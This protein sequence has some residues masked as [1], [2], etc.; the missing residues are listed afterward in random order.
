MCPPGPLLVFAVLGSPPTA[1][2]SSLTL[3]GERWDNGQWSAL[4]KA[5]HMVGP[6][7]KRGDKGAVAIES[8]RE[9]PDVRRL[10]P[11]VGGP[12]DSNLGSKERQLQKAASKE[13]QKTAAAAAVG[14]AARDKDIVRQIMHP[15]ALSL[16]QDDLNADQADSDGQDHQVHPVLVLV[17]VVVLS[18]L[19]GTPRPRG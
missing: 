10:A 13:R 16:G 8:A 12:K 19:S 14:S 1:T 11:A 7:L 3:V 2:F 17:L 9:S 15:S 5:G 18:G 4:D 6:P